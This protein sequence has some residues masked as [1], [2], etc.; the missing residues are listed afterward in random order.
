MQIFGI[1]G[2][3]RVFPQKT[4]FFGSDLWRR[5]NERTRACLKI[6]IYPHPGPPIFPGGV[7]SRSWGTRGRVPP[8]DTGL[9]AKFT[10]PDLRVPSKNQLRSGRNLGFLAGPQ[11]TPPGTPL[12]DRFFD[13]PNWPPGNHFFWPSPRFSV[14]LG[15][16]EMS[17][18][19]VFLG[20]G[21]IWCFWKMYNFDPRPLKMN[22]SSFRLKSPIN[23]VSRS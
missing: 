16:L 14:F 19:C 23:E 22:K 3:H 9:A 4:Q 5:L 20:I 18:F 8:R 7:V 11:K 17:V 21:R 2:S 6:Y 1:S 10:P 13:P 15:F 12:P